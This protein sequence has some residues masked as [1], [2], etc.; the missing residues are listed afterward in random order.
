[1]PLLPLECVDFRERK[2]AIGFGRLLAERL[3]E[4]LLSYWD[5]S[6]RAHLELYLPARITHVP[7]MKG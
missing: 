3:E 4:R 2:H 6:M 7:K 1:M 5:W